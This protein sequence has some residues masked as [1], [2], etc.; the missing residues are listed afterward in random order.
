[1]FR[2]NT[3]PSSSACD[4]LRTE[5]HNIE[6]VSSGVSDSISVLGRMSGMDDMINALRGVRDHLDDEQQSAIR[7]E[8][9]LSWIG[10]NFDQCENKI[11]ECAEQ[12]RQIYPVMNVTETGTGGY[13]SDFDINIT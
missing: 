8:K 3:G 13:S 5:Q 1:M 4:S 11:V 7:L 9:A 2:I 10:H 6:D 12:S